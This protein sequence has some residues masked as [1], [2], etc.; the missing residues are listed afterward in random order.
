VVLTIEDNGF[1]FDVVNAP[2]KEIATS[3]DGLVPGGL[4]ITL[5]KR[6]ASSLRYARRA[7]L[8]IVVAEFVDPP[9]TPAA[10]RE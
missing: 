2:A 1:E 9:A 3:I 8:N 10:G 7:N 5:V 4:G 6:F